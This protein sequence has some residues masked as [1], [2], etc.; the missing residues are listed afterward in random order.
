MRAFGTLA[1]LTGISNTGTAM[2]TFDETRF[3]KIEDR[4]HAIQQML[5][6]H[7]AASHNVDDRLLDT[8]LE[9]A[10]TQYISA[11]ASG[12]NRV[13]FHL[14]GMISDLREVCDLPPVE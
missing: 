11:V 10:Q 6:A 12:H 5:L 3:E 4:V 7:I 13:A 8:T 2:R 1:R 14:E 9:I